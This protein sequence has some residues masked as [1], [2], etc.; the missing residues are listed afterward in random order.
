[1]RRFRMAQQRGQENRLL[2]EVWNEKE[3]SSV[4]KERTRFQRPPGS[5]ELVP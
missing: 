1:M 2:K 4:T 3:Q 5:T